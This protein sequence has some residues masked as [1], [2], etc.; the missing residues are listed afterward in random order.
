MQT[1][2]MIDLTAAILAGGL[3]TRLRPAVGDRPKV[4]AEISGRPFLT[5]LFDQLLHAGIRR[6]VLCTGY[7]GE[8]VRAAFGDSYGSLHLLYSQETFL[9]G[10]AGALRL[11]LPLLESESVLVMNGDSYC[12]LDLQAFW[13][14]H[15]GRQATASLALAQLSD[16]RRYGRVEVDAEGTVL[17]F[18][19]KGYTDEPGW[20]NAGIYLLQRSLLLKIPAKG[21][22]SL[23]RELFPVWIG[24]GLYGYRSKGRFLD[25]G[26]PEDYAEVQEFFASQTVRAPVDRS[27]GS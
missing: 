23:E 27:I 25:I 12:E 10:T 8:Q 22:V 17:S 1:P 11:A 2:L 19:E 18:Y 21:A 6:V 5:F 13:T 24:Y 20:V 3:G 7:L 26:T 4:L 15:R 9:L 16:T 14:W